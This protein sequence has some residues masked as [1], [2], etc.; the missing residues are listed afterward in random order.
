MP[1]PWVDALKIYNSQHG[2]KWSIPRKGTPEYEAVQKIMMGFLG[3]KAQ[4]EKRKG[5][6]RPRKDEVRRLKE[7]VKPEAAEAAESHV[8]PEIVEPAP[9]KRGRGRP[10]KIQVP[11][12]AEPAPVKRGRGRPRKVEKLAPGTA[13]A[14]LPPTPSNPIEAEVLEKAIRPEIPKEPMAAAKPKAVPRPRKTLESVKAAKAAMVVHKP[15]ESAHVERDLVRIAER[16]VSEAIAKATEEIS[17]KTAAKVV[18]A[19]RAEKAAKKPKLTRPESKLFSAAIP[20]IS[21]AKMDSKK[22]FIAVFRKPLQVLFQLAED[23]EDGKF[24]NEKEPNLAES[25]MTDRFVKF[26]GRKADAGFQ[27]HLEVHD[28]S[29]SKNIKFVII[30]DPEDEEKPVRFDAKD[31]DHEKLEKVRELVEKEGKKLAEAESA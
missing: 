13:E 14:P 28:T 30:Y 19:K 17:T 20:H 22:Y 3:T 9:A 31:L 24:G 27:T 6:G 26:M 10:R 1:T 23:Y 7:E 12:P 29:L 5:P 2:G 8:E 21:G 4:M 11:K 16:L 18:V 15:K 25:K